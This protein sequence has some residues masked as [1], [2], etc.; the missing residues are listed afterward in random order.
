[1]KAIYLA[2]LCLL[3]SAVTEGQYATAQKSWTDVFNSRDTHLK[4]IIRLNSL[5]INSP[6][7]FVRVVNESADNTYSIAELTTVVRMA[8]D[9]CN[10][11]KETGLLLTGWLREDHKI[12]K[13]K[14]PTE[15]NQFRSFLLASLA[16]FPP[17]DN[18]YQYIKSELLFPSHAINIAAASLCAG[19]FPQNAGELI[20]LM[21]PFL[22]SSFMDEWVD[23][24]TP[25][26]N[27]PVEHPTKARYEIISTF[28]KFAPAS[29]RSISLLRDIVRCGNCDLFGWDSLLARK[30]NIAAAFI[31]EKT[32]SCCRKPVA[33]VNY[34]K[35][36]QVISRAERKF[37][38][39]MDIRLL[40]QEGQQL[41]F[42]DLRGKPFVLTFFLYTMQQPDQMCLDR[43]TFAGSQVTL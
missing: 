30:A 4:N 18:L 26:L 6:E 19:N 43:A 20:S 38:T 1:M 32:P 24:T 17:N 14:T 35:P 7:E 29:Y 16:A 22:R 5:Q 33:M 15:T 36:L 10:D 25:R 2:G 40:D 13:D 3:L 28:T 39:E 8:R 42:A 37:I 11:S 12:Y 9:Y 21:E 31:V 27:Y 41:R 23:L 34:S